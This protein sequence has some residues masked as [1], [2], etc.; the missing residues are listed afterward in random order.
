MSYDQRPGRMRVVGQ[1]TPQ[2]QRRRGDSPQESDAAQLPA[3]DAVPAKPRGLSLLLI[4]LFLLGSAG[5]G[6]AVAMAAHSGMLGQ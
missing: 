5:G 4:G 3:V 1:S 6:V 2:P